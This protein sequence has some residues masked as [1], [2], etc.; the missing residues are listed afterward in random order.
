MPAPTTPMVPVPAAATGFAQRRSRSRLLVPVGLFAVVAAL[1]LLFR[2]HGF[3]GSPRGAVQQGTQRAPVG[4]SARP[5][6]SAPDVALLDASRASLVR[7]VSGKIGQA[8]AFEVGAGPSL[9]AVSSQLAHF[10][11]TPVAKLRVVIS[12]PGATVGVGPE[13][14]LAADNYAKPGNELLVQDAVG[15]SSRVAVSFTPAAGGSYPVVA[16]TESVAPCAL[17]NTAQV[18]YRAV[19]VGSVEVPSS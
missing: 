7:T 5:G 1:S 18:T 10:D 14:N 2:S 3:A 4:L 19:Q 16:Y 9:K 17:T 13:A 11:L 6:C 8:V 12:K 15:G